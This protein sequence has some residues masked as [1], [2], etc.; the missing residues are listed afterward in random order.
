M[1]IS[2]HK[3]PEKRVYFVFGAIIQVAGQVFTEYLLLAQKCSIWCACGLVY[4]G[5]GKD[6]CEEKNARIN[7]IWFIP[8]Q[9]SQA[10]WQRAADTHYHNTVSL[11]CKRGVLKTLKELG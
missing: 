9:S 4:G 1:L 7:T 11:H 3:Q 8:P 2:E 6:G 5:S 10:R